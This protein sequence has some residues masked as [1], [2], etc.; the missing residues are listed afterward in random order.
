[1]LLLLGG[2]CDVFR[3]GTNG[4]AT[5]AGAGAVAAAGAAVTPAYD[6]ATGSVAATGGVC[7]IVF[8]AADDDGDVIVVLVVVVATSDVW[9]LLNDGCVKM[10]LNM[11]SKLVS[12]ILHL[13]SIIHISLSICSPHQKRQHHQQQFT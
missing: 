2:G 5:G 1:M 11:S 4:T 10:K 13:V 7:V 3:T 9:L 6:A 8:A 12:F